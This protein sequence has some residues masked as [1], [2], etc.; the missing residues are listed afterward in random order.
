[1]PVCVAAMKDLMIDWVDNHMSENEDG[2]WYAEDELAMKGQVFKTEEELHKAL[3]DFII[4]N[5]DRLFP[6]VDYHGEYC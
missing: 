2:T 6:S 1:M 5:Q 3:W 4:E